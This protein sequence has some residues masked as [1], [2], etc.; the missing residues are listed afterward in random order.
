MELYTGT[1]QVRIDD[2]L[3]AM[4]FAKVAISERNIL[5]ELRNTRQFRTA[6]S[7]ELEERIDFTGCEVGHMT[8]RQMIDELER[9]PSWLPCKLYGGNNWA[10]FNLDLTFDSSR[11]SYANLA[12]GFDTC[13]PPTVA[14]LI[15]TLEN[16][17][18]GSTQFGWKGGEFYM[19][20]DTLVDLGNRGESTGLGFV[21]IFTDSDAAYLEVADVWGWHTRED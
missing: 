10:E 16:R 15:D 5:G 7:Y 3:V 18:L 21:R 17:A 8:I 14:D 6:E 12:L 13:E 2:E 1:A 19:W 4:P 9:M 20:N 11:S